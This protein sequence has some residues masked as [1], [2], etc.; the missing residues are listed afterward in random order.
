MAKF[1]DEII[2]LKNL[3]RRGW[4]I[5]FGKDNVR[6]ESDAE[7]IY[8][9]VMLA[10]K[11]KSDRKLKLDEAK[12]MK[13]ILV[14]ELGEIDVGDITPIDDIPSK[15]KY[16]KE[17]ECVER[18]SRVFGQDEYFLLWQEFEENKTEEARLAKVVDKLDCVLQA[19]HYAE[20]LNKPEVYEEFYENAKDKIKGYEEYLED[21]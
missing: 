8:S 14:H 18:V 17:K 2:K 16:L 4:A 3:V 15:Q 1:Y 19:K 21:K 11:I 13:M 12:L 5:R 9:M 10:L 6:L 7:H 20:R